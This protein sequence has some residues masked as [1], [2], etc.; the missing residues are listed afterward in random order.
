MNLKGWECPK[1]GSVYSPWVNECNT[2]KN[3]NIRIVTS[4]TTVPGGSW[5]TGDPVPSPYTITSSG[6]REEK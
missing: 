4:P 3:S 6:N 1:C 2:C 5:S